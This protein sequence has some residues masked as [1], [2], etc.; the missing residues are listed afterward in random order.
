MPSVCYKHH[1]FSAEIV[2]HG[3]WL[4]VRFCLSYRDGEELLFARG[5]SRCMGRC[6]NS[7]GNSANRMPINSGAG[8]PNPAT[9]GTS[10]RHF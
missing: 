9:R 5:L 10:M 6:A 3:G 2:G 7:A 8:A 4:Y 1:R